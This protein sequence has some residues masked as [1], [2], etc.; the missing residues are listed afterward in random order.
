VR[1][2]SVDAVSV[3][4]TRFLPTRPTPRPWMITP[5]LKPVRLEFTPVPPS[6]LALSATHRLMDARRNTIQQ[7]EREISRK[8]MKVRCKMVNR[9]R[10]AKRRKAKPPLDDLFDEEEEEKWLQEEREERSEGMAESVFL[11]EV[12]AMGHDPC[13][14]PR[15]NVSSPGYKRPCLPFNLVPMRASDAGEA[16]LARVH[17]AFDL[18]NVGVRVSVGPRGYVFDG[19]GVELTNRQRLQP[20]PYCFTSTWPRQLKRLVKYAERGFCV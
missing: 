14:V 5:G 1:G 8:Y 16:C 7:V 3:D 18:V 10:K 12:S 11:A 4:L 19:P 9:H 17:H 20:T 6:L 15:T 2:G 13:L